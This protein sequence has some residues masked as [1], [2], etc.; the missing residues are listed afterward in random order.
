MLKVTRGQ[1]ISRGLAN[2]CPNCAAKSLFPS[3][4]HFTINRTW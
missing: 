3:G 1:I 4:A 2:T